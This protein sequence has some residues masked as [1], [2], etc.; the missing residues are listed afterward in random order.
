MKTRVREKIEGMI[1]QGVL[2]EGSRR[3]YFANGQ[4][5]REKEKSKES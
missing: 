5:S 1:E 3:I 2:I 4:H